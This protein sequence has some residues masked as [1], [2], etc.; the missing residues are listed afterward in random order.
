MIKPK[1]RVSDDVSDP[2][3]SFTKNFDAIDSGLGDQEFVFGSIRTQVTK[4]DVPDKPKPLVIDQ[5]NSQH[6]LTMGDIMR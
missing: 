2:D 5:N 6:Q 1:D 3:K 4:I